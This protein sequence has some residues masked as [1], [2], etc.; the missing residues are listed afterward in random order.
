VD[1][2]AAGLVLDLT[3]RQGPSRPVLLRLDL[4]F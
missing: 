1:P 4:E 2:V 3:P